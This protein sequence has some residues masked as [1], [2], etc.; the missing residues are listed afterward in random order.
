MMKL[1]DFSKKNGNKTL[2]DFLNKRRS[3]S[4][5]DTSIV[6]KIINDV[7]K[8]KNK[9]V[10]KYEKKCDV[11]VICVGNL[12]L[13]G[14]GKTPTVIKIREILSDYFEDIYERKNL[15]YII[16]KAG[17]DF[18]SLLNMSALFISRINYVVMPEEI[19]NQKIKDTKLLKSI[20]NNL[21]SIL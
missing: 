3:G 15:D 2:L 14:A 9:A 8:N 21:I 11:P 13:G 19:N 18:S 20:E 7:K 17:K 1:I 6:D 12:T 5:V 10:I 4:R 16:L